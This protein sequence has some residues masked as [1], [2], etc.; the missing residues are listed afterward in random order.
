MPMKT[1]LP[2]PVG[3]WARFAETL[4]PLSDDSPDRAVAEATQVIE[5]FLPRYESHWLA[6]ARAKLGLEASAD[7]E[8]RALARDWLE[9]LEEHTV[10]YTLAWR[11]LAEAAEGKAESLEALFPSELAIRPWLDR[12]RRRLAGRPP[13]ESAEAIRAANPIYIPRNHLVEEA[14][15]AASDH[16]C[17]GPFERLLGAITQ[18]YLERPGLEDCALPAPG[19]FTA[20]YKTYCGT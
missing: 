8:D 12:W 16:D 7:D 6:G 19:E 9:L 5:G 3:T 15:T 2:S 10:D 1:N 14:L 11:R 17:L 4:L 20:A 13:R 18:P